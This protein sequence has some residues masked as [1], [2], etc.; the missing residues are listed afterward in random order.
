VETWLRE[1]SVKTILF[2]MG[3]LDGKMD[4]ISRNLHQKI[5]ELDLNIQILGKKMDRLDERVAT[6]DQKMNAPDQPIS[7]W[8]KKVVNS[9]AQTGAWKQMEI[10]GHLKKDAMEPNGETLGQTATD[11]AE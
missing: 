6:L 11:E 4:H 9:E 10:D 3:K 2:A 7:A 5:E 1:E 8:A